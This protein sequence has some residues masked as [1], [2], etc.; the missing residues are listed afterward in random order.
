MK[1]PIEN[2]LESDSRE[3]IYIHIPKTGGRSVLSVLGLKFQS[4]HRTISDYVEELGENEVRRRF[5]FASVRNPWDRAVSWWSFFGNMGFKRTPF[6]DWLRKLAKNWIPKKYTG[7]FHLDQMSYC[8]IST[9]EVLIDIFIRF[10]HINE[11]WSAVASRIG[12]HAN[13]PWIGKDHK[14]ILP[15]TRE[16]MLRS[17]HPELAPLVPTDDFHDM[18]T[19]QELIDIVARLDAE[20]IERFGYTFR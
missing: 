1:S 9:N 2:E 15:R 5:K 14:Q 4:S 3:Y 10:E 20:T 8:K 6:E 19:S 7:R 17:K 18:Y 16:A 13:L 11:D 12:V